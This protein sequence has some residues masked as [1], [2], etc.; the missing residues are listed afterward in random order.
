MKRRETESASNPF[1][2]CSP[3]SRIHRDSQSCVEKRTGGREEIEGPGGEK[4]ESK[5]GE[6]GQVS[7]LALK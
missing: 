3:P 7:N 6:S 5:G 2:K 4:G 1:P